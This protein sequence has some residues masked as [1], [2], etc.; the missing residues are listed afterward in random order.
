MVAT[1]RNTD[2]DNRQESKPLCQR[3]DCRWEASRRVTIEATQEVQPPV[4]LYGV[5]F[6]TIINRLVFPFRRIT[7][8]LCSG[9]YLFDIERDKTLQIISVDVIDPYGGKHS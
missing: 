2:G 7:V 8:D 6:A 3:G 1:N 4:T 5:T 9:C